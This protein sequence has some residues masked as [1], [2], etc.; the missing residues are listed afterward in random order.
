MASRRVERI[1][2]LIQSFLASHIQKE[3]CGFFIGNF[4]HAELKHLFVRKHYCIRHIIPHCKT[5][6]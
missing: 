6:L 1:N 3:F 4:M 5:P 2:T